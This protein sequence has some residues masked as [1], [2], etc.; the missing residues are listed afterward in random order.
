MWDLLLFK[1]QCIPYPVS[2]DRI[3]CDS[4]LLCRLDY[5]QIPD[6][7][8]SASSGQGLRACLQELAEMASVIAKPSSGPEQG[9]LQYSDSG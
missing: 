8:A 5:L 2:A 3:C 1:Q 9:R 7:A 4:E 6:S